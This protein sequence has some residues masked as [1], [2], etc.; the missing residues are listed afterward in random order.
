MNKVSNATLLKLLT[1]VVVWHS[2]LEKVQIGYY[3]IAHE[4]L[5]YSLLANTFRL[6]TFMPSACTLK[7]MGQILSHNNRIK[8]P[9]DDDL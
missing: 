2:D 5:Q 8:L 6:S 4:E 1:L 3:R 7:Q 9:W